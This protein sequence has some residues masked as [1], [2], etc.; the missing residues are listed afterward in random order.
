MFDS[1]VAAWV[2]IVFLTGPL[3]SQ[4]CSQEVQRTPDDFRHSQSNFNA[5]EFLEA[6]QQQA[7]SC[8]PL[9]SVEELRQI[10]DFVRTEIGTDY[11]ITYCY[12]LIRD[13]KDNCVEERRFARTSSMLLSSRTPVG[14]GGIAIAKSY[15]G[16]VVRQTQTI[17]KQSY[18]TKSETLDYSSFVDIDGDVIVR[19]LVFDLAEAFHT[20]FIFDDIKVFLSDERSTGEIWIGSKLTKIGDRNCFVIARPMFD[21]WVC[22]DLNFAI[23]RIC[24][25]SVDDGKVVVIEKVDFSDFREVKKGIYVP[26]HMESKDQRLVGDGSTA[27]KE[28]KQ[29]GDSEVVD[30]IEYLPDYILESNET[31]AIFP[32]T[33]IVRDEIN[34]VVSA[35]DTESSIEAMLDYSIALMKGGRTCLPRLNRY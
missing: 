29:A 30:V 31:K 33:A 35:A 28:I 24:H 2:V 23:C 5:Q 6:W 9:Y 25:H 20:N 17:G 1:V 14:G 13:G 27:P 21:V 32:S 26:F 22:P 34:Q 7:A 18:G 11:S 16:S 12:K 10:F 3:L 8:E 15:D 4:V 19:S